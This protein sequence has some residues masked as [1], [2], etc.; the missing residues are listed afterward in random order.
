MPFHLC[1]FSASSHL[2]DCQQRLLMPLFNSTD[3]IWIFY[4]FMV[5]GHWRLLAQWIYTYATWALCVSLKTIIQCVRA[6]NIFGCNG[7]MTMTNNNYGYLII[8]RIQKWKT[9]TMKTENVL[10]RLIVRVSGLFVHQIIWN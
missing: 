3:F 1:S 5:Y 4:L 9:K 6:W 2:C 10:I 8:K 7:F